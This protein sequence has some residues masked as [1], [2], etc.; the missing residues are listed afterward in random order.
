MCVFSERYVYLR[1]KM[2][3][4]IQFSGQLLV[5]FGQQDSLP[6]VLLLVL[7]LKL[8]PLALA[9]ENTQTWSVKLVT[10]K[11]FVVFQASELYELIQ[12]ILYRGFI[13]TLNIQIFTD[14]SSILLP[15]WLCG[16]LTPHLNQRLGSENRY[17]L[18]SLN[19]LIQSEPDPALFEQM[20][21]KAVRITCP[22]SRRES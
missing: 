2:S 13:N 16:P 10:F 9:E 17:T 11:W 5:L 4:L 14:V 22:N 18:L 6:L 19:T 8:F 7:R 15:L 12:A 3:Y 20:N 1:V 21:E